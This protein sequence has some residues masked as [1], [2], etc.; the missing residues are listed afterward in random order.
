[1]LTASKPGRTGFSSP[2]FPTLIQHQ[3]ALSVPM[4]SAVVLDASKMRHIETCASPILR[5]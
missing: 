3:V 2:R 1:M 4:P 5:A